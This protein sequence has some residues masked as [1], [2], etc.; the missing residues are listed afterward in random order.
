QR[1]DDIGGAFGQRVEKHELAPGAE[2][3][4]SAS[5]Q[6]GAPVA[7]EPPSRQPQRDEGRRDHR[8]GPD[9]VAQR[10]GKPRALRGFDERPPDSPE[11]GGDDCVEEPKPGSHPEFLQLFRGPSDRRLSGMPVKKAWRPAIQ[12]N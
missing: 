7:V 1:E 8:E 3:P 11:G 4:G 12:E 2:Q 10:G 5:K 6:Y 9:R